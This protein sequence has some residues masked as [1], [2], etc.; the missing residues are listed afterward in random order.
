MYILQ[1]VLHPEMPL[2]IWR[3]QY[4]KTI[5]IFFPSRGIIPL[6]GYT[7]LNR[8]PVCGVLGYFQCFLFKS[9]LQ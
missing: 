8:A 6:N 7:K 4:I 1:T 5:F 3:Y 9:G 2:P